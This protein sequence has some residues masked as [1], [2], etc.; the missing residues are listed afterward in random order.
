MRTY[1]AA[2]KMVLALTLLVGVAYPLATVAAAHL[3]FLHH[4]AEGSRTA[5]GSTLIGQ[6]FTDAQGD[7]LPQYF[8][9]RPD[10][11]DPTAS[12]AGNLGPESV[13]DVLPTPGNPGKASLLTTVCTRSLNVGKLEGVSGARPFCTPDG[14]GAV[15]GVYYSGGN[16]GTVTRVVSLDQACPATP[17]LAAYRGVR[18]EC[19]KPGTDYSAA[20]VTP[21]RGDAPA[22]PAVPAD[23]VTG[24]ASGLDPDISPDYARLQAPRVA[25][26]RNVPVAQ[27]LKLVDEHTTGRALGFLGEPV[28]NVLELNVDLD[29]TYPA[30]AK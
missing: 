1:L 18:V 2:L 6:S 5:A 28:A 11:E 10:G 20:V 17:F 9:S 7:A 16:A 4:K 24:S 12:G 22:H 3:P 23:A 19:A 26:A 21:I 29:H 14:V 8:Q 13:V 30:K 25:A 27:V 15:L